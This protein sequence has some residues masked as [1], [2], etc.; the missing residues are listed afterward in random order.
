MEKKTEYNSW[1]NYETWCVLLWLTNE[2]GSYRYWS[3]EAARHLE[4]ARDCEVVRAGKQ[5]PEEESRSSLAKQ[6]KKDIGDASPLS[7]ASGSLFVDLLYAALT[8]VDWYEVAA[9][10]LEDVSQ[11]DQPSEITE[12]EA[13]ADNVAR[14]PEGS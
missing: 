2:E 1:S 8:Q 10:F 4:A 12:S 14:P 7:H 11:E 6:L 5:T 13:H 3:E 9:A